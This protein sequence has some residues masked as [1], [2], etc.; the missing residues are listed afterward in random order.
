MKFLFHS[1]A[2]NTVV[3]KDASYMFLHSSHQ[4]FAEQNCKPFVVGDMLKLGNNDSS[5]LLKQS[6]VTPVFIQFVQISGYTI[7][8]SNP[9]SG[10]RH[11]C[12]DQKEWLNSLIWLKRYYSNEVYNLG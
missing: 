2:N 3:Y 1:W 4:I 11:Q 7:V 8:L 6:L 5:R 12:C 9:Q 10:H